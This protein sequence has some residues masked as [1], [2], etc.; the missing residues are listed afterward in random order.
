MPVVCKTARRT[1]MGAKRILTPLFLPIVAV[2]PNTFTENLALNCRECQG[3]KRKLDAPLAFKDMQK[4]DL[5]F[6]T[7]RAD[8]VITHVGIY[9]GERLLDK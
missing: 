2:G 7:T 5:M 9:M 4:G 6:F 3:T 1:H 8:K